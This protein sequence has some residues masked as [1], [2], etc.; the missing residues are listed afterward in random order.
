M[1]AIKKLIDQKANL[2]VRNENYSVPLH[3]AAKNGN[4]EN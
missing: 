3:L 4:F 1:D 2:N